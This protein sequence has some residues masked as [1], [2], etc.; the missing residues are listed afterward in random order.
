MMVIDI[1]S[2][3]E[4][5]L[6]DLCPEEYFADISIAYQ[7]E[8]KALYDAGCRTSLYFNLSVRP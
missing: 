4:I 1:P 7:Q 6:I 8:F 5:P 2:P 3:Q